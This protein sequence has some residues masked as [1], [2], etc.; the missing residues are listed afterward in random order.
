M[1][2]HTPESVGDAL[3]ES[4]LALPPVLFVGH[5]AR[6]LELKPS[7]VR[8]M[9]RRGEIPLARVGRRFAISRIRFLAWLDARTVARTR[10]ASAPSRAT[11]RDGRDS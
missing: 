2:T 4:G 8:A 10:P 5:V 3:R 9:Y 6:A 1:P 11:S 7:G